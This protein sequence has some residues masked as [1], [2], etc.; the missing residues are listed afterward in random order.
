MI[1]K[2]RDSWGS[3]EGNKMR[4][5]AFFIL[6]LFLALNI[7]GCVPLIIGGAAGAA[8]AYAVSKDTVQAD[9]DKSYDSLWG[10]ALTV[11]RIRG[12][13]KEENAQLGYIE[14]QI[15]SSRVWIRLVRLTRSATRVRISARR[16]HLPNLGLAQEMYLKIIEEA[17]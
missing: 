15:E 16:H 1:R 8:G 13:I 4:K 11:T 3:R 5:P 10:A 9:T 14:A 6:L 12:T 17:K 7:S 2:K